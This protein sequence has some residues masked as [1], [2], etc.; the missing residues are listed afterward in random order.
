MVGL[1]FAWQGHKGFSLWDEGFLWY[2]VQRVL[3]GETPILDF[4][5]Y[6]PGRY[7]WSAALLG[8]AGDPGS[9]MGVRASVVIFQALG[10]CV[11]MLVIACST[12]KQQRG[13]LLLWLIA[14][15]SLG[16]WMY[17]RHKLFD[18]S[19]SML[20]IGI[21]TLLAAK[22]LPRSYFLA[23]VVVGMAAVFGRN[24]GLYGAVGSLG[25]VAWLRIGPSTPTGAIKGLLYWSAGV[26]AGFLPIAVMALFIPGFA[27]A[28]VESVRLLFEQSGTNLP[29]PI[30]W[31]WTVDFRALP[32]GQLVRGVLTGTF[33][34]G[35]LI[36]GVTTIAAVCIRRAAGRSVPP[37][38]VA[39]AFLA[40]PYAHYAFSRADV[41]H[42]AHGVYPL[43]IGCFVL[44]ASARPLL[45]WPLSLALCAASIWVMYVF[46]PGW[47][48]WRSDQCVNINIAGSQL[49]VDSSVA[50]DVALLRQLT[51]QYAPSNESFIA[52]PFWP[53]A[54]ALLERKAPVWEIYPLFP[55]TPAFEQKEI[56]R[57]KAA[58][59]AFA[60]V[61]DM[62]LDGREE[63]RFRNTHPLIHQY[64]M[65][66]FERI[67]DAAHP[68]YQIYKARKNGA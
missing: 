43:L 34:I 59:I 60:I 63:L 33:F 57:I 52:A 35:L 32:F 54:Y 44:L 61:F 53:G 48:C 18:I 16:V 3:A 22:P 66:H 41:G 64:I 42:L 26:A 12:P 11:A 31:P 37:A 40:L 10:L 51:N 28:F 5:A 58:D 24:H 65:D 36:F 15:V 23:G 29:L 49:I 17:P 7:Y 19:L 62:P 2:G 50:N 9:I 39:C 46:H 67:P 8:I 47:L 20:L 68:T 38:L 27:A 4:M 45:R 55:R 30:P 21:L 56:E 14:C 1:S 13:N 6:D 25:V